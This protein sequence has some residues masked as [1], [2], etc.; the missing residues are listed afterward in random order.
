MSKPSLRRPPGRPRAGRRPAVD[1]QVILD[2]AVRL[3][4]DAGLDGLTMRRLAAEVDLEVIGRGTPGMTGADLENLVNEAALFA[5][6]QSKE[7]VDMTDFEAAKD[8]VLMGPERKSMI[9]SE[10]E[11]R[12]TAVHEAGHALTARLLPGCDPLHKVTI[13]PRGQALGLTMALPIEDKHNHYRKAALDQIAMAM[14]GRIAEELV[15]DEM[16]S[17]AAS[18]IEHATNL[19]RAMVCR[20]GMSQKL[21]PLAFGNRDGEVFLGRDLATRPDYSEDT[22]RQIDLEVREIVMSCYDRGKKLLVQNMETLK[23][24]GDALLEYETLDAEDV[25]VLL[26]GGS[27]TRARPPPRITA[28]P[29]LEKKE[30][31]K[32]LDAL[33]GLPKMEP[34]KA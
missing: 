7:R 21:G 19:A 9:M 33:E 34:N 29:K 14:G 5:A 12:I 10:K 1:R 22:A 24:I 17:G 26:A 23:R 13:I 8:K 25:N 16:S 3:V 28:P 15:F 32:I 31:R 6:R 27:L 11:K 2:A 20:W 18:D 4:E 30:K